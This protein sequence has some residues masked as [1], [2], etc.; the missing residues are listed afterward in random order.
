MAIT[1]LAAAAARWADPDYAPRA[2]AV[3]ATLAENAEYTFEAVTFAVNQTMS[4]LTSEALAA[5]QGGRRAEVPRTVGVLHAGNIP[6][7]EV[8]DFAAVLLAGHRY[9]GVVS[10]RS[11]YLLPAFAR[12]VAGAAPGLD[13]AF[14]DFEALLSQAD[15]LIATACCAATA[16]ARPCSTGASRRTRASAWPRTCCYTKAAAAAASPSCGR[17]RG[18]TLIRT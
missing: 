11:A 13:V 6:M 2:E 12:D 8:Q 5:W 4:G 16:S 7:A 15:A 10:S 9:R 3:A 14:S 18:S 1:A 17:R